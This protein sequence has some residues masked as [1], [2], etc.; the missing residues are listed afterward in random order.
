MTTSTKGVLDATT[1]GTTLASGRLRVW[2]I[3]FFVVSAAAPLTVVVSAAPAAFRLGGIGAPGAMIFAAVVL[4][5]FALGFTAMSTHVRNAGAF[6]A[7]VGKGLGKPAGIGIAF[8]TVLAYAVLAIAFYGFIGFFAQ[9]TA[10]NLLG[11]DVPWWVW[12]L[13]SV[14]VVALLGARKIDVGAKV[15][16]VLLGAEV[17][18]LLILTV[19]I[20]ITG[21][22][23][24]ASA[25]P[26]SPAAVFGAPGV[27]ALIVIAFGAFLGFEGTAIYA[28]EA[29]RPEKTVPRATYIAVAFLGVFYAFTFWILTYAF[30]I[31][32]VLALA[33]SDDFTEMVFI[34]G[35][36]YLGAWAGVA[37]QVLIVTSFFACVLAF[38]NAT[39]RYLFSLGRE[40]LLP[41]ALARTGQATGSPYVASFAMAALAALAVVVA[42]VLGADPYLQL[43]IWTYAVGVAGVIFAQAV[44]AISA[45]AFF[46]KDRRGHSVWRVIVA[47]A[48]GAL[49]L[50][51]AFC[52]VTANFEIVSGFTGPI[53]WLLLLPTPVLFVAGIVV[54]FVLRRRAP[55][56]YEG[57][58]QSIPIIEEEPSQ[59]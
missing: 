11:L 16:A 31:D 36:Q 39:S 4:I 34:A 40:G 12:A 23:E 18:I 19:A 44:A 30:G 33:Q 29:H 50:I 48:F 7:Y 54:G 51:V 45:V 42:A 13:A 32:G 24:P 21:G 52:L 5:L 14:G 57:L 8:V 56:T 25:L 2:D 9:L 46:A 10:V 27:A 41:R 17:L 49:G 22:P 35:D 53:N 1:T 26:F 38:H 59:P 15:L 3:V 6:Y 20:L 55:K 37:M 47:P 28:E 58:T 43:A